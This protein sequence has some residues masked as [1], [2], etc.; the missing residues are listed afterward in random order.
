MDNTTVDISS[1]KGHY[2][3]QKRHIIA[4]AANKNMSPQIL[5]IFERVSPRG[6]TKPGLD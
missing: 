4:S 2:R 1:H 6:L 3:M 5:R